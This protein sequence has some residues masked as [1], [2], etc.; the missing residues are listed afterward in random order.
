MSVMLTLRFS[1]PM[2]LVKTVI[3]ISELTLTEEF[4]YKMT[5]T[6]LKTRSIE[7]T[8]HVPHVMI[9]RTHLKLNKEFVL[10]ILVTT[11]HKF[12]T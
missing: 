12:L 10:P 11:Q 9:T 1:W 7:P 4:A 6:Q 2:E 8:E 5:V 3:L